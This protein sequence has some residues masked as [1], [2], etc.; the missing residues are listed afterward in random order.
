MILKPGSELL[1][2]FRHSPRILICNVPEHLKTA[3]S[4]LLPDTVQDLVFDESLH[5]FLTDNAVILAAGGKEQMKASIAR[6]KCCQLPDSHCNTNLTIL[7]YR[8]SAIRLCWHHDNKVREW[9][10]PDLD[11]LARYNTIEWILGRIGSDLRMQEDHQLTVAEICWWS[12]LKKVSDRLP[13]DVARSVLNLPKL[14]TLSGEMKEADIRPYD[15]RAVPVIEKRAVAALEGWEP[16]NKPVIRLVGDAEPAQGFMLRPKLKRWECEKYTR[17]VKTQECC[18]CRQPADDPHHIIG[19]GQ[20]GMGTKAHDLFV[21]PL[22]R[23]CHGEIHADTK[24][25]E[26]KHGSQIELL[27]R[28]LDRALGIGAIL[29][30]KK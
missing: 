25:W 23:R 5:P 7:E 28:F 18:N 8:D 1:P 21:I 30:A 3:V 10:T 12:V 14:P 27:F 29:I 22:C 6:K 17:W 16:L 9:T 26:Q 4:G 15:D 24:A 20:G 11:E 13:E 2:S 19:H